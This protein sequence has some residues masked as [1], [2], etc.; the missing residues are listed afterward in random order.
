MTIC[1]TLSKEKALISKTV[2]GY[3]AT[4]FASNPG[5]L[6]VC[7]VEERQSYSF[8]QILQFPE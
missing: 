6:W 2:M 1:L 7:S 4:G 8:K 3:F 5:L